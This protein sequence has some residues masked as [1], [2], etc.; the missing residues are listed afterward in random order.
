MKIWGVVL[1][2]SPETPEI[3]QLVA[4]YLNA[5]GIRTEITPIEQPRFMSDLVFQEPQRF[6]TSFA[7][8]LHVN[9]PFPRPFVMQ[10]LR[11][12]FISRKA[13]GV[14]AYYP[15]YDFIDREYARLQQI[16]TLEELGPELR[17]LNRA[18]HE[19]YGFYPVVARS[20]AFAVGPKVA[21]WSPGKYGLAW[22][23]ETVKRAR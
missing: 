20:L 7:C 17:K 8:H 2:N 11:V 18:I 3:L 22:H 21:Q 23:L 9:V 4:G 16:T 1:S 5:V 13:G 19:A 6:D 10:N 12:S 15:E 14:P